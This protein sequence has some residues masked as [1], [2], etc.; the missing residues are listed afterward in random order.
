ML[1][2]ISVELQHPTCQEHLFRH[3]LNAGN[4]N[5]SIVWWM[6]SFCQTLWTTS[7]KHVSCLRKPEIC[8]NQQIVLVFKKEDLT[9]IYWILL[10]WFLDLIYVT[11]DYSDNLK[12]TSK[13]FTN[14]DKI[15][16]YIVVSLKT[17]WFFLIFL[18]VHFDFNLNK[19]TQ[20]H[21]KWEIY[22]HPEKVHPFLS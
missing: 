8:L 14:F 13:W 4:N 6:L 17:S 9:H 10:L 16:E 7:P 19:F 1:Q 11:S 12:L 3:T 20:R 22:V 15:I 2:P 21:W 5:F 18:F